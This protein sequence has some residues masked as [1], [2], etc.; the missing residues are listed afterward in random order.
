[1]TDMNNKDIE[2][3]LDQAGPRVKPEQP[4]RDEVYKEV[5][6][7][8]LETHKPPFYQAHAVKIAASLF[9]FISLF[10]FTLLYKGDQP[11]Y[12]IAQ[13]IE[14]QGQIQISQ[15][16]EDWFYLDNDK[17]ISPGDYLKTQRNNR[18]LVN[19]FN[20]NQFR[21]DENTHL[22][23]E[24]NNHLSL[25]SGR[26]Y[27]DSD[28]TDGHHKLTID[29]PL[30]K[31]N[32]IGT[33]Y[34]V[35]YIGKQLNVGVRDGLVLVKGGRI[36]QSEIV[37]GR[38]LMLNTNGEVLY[39]NI[40]TY[41]PVWHWTQKITDGF[42]I[43]DRTLS[44]YLKWVS[45]ETGYPIKWE[46]DT[47]KNKAESI[48]LSGSINGILPVDSLDVIIPTTRFKYSLDDNQIY[49]HNENG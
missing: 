22:K 13:S 45:T 14:I 40:E 7:M 38:N 46:S 12:N 23:V 49:I 42:S 1:M 25:L 30:A 9:L 36:A 18:L 5:H 26:I 24:S 27:I 33:Q 28:S 4:V 44:D 17:T 48:K 37:K 10:S 31:V 6:D 47:V 21:V 19:L 15:N 39:S 8:W 32:H 16:N 20:G 34:S 2:K 3:I 11:V 29:T 41:D 43:Q 35:S